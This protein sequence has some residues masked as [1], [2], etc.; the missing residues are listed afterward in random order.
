[1]KPSI[2]IT[3]LLALALLLSACSAPTPEGE[4]TLSVEQQAGTQ[5]ALTVEAFTTQMAQQPTNTSEPTATEEPEATITPEPTN[6]VPVIL[7]PTNTNVVVATQAPC[8]KAAFVSDVTVPDDTNFQPGET[9]TK[10]W[11]LRNVGTCTWTS[12]YKLIFKSGNSLEGPASVNLPGNV[13]PNETVDISIELKAPATAG[14]YQGYY[15]LANANGVEFGVGPTGAES[16][17]VKIRVG[18]GGPTVT[19]GGPTV[20]PGGPTATVTR[21]PDLFAVTGVDVRVEPSTYTGACPVQLSISASVTVNRAG[22]I[23]Y[24]WLIDGVATE[25]QS[26]EFD[27]AGTKTVSLMQQIDVGGAHT[28]AFRNVVPNNQ[29]F[30]LTEIMITCQ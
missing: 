28:V 15:K 26:L 27:A 25:T 6:T 17:W 12:G 29:T 19:P 18:G 21:T 11:R 30:D 23:T 7:A 3:S 24:F 8:D 14:T 22:T 20:T 16:F 9:F 4:P 1:M 13:A 5:A 10:T 2:W